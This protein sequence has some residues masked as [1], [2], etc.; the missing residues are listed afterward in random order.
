M[1]FTNFVIPNKFEDLVRDDGEN[2]YVKTIVDVC[3]LPAKL[4]DGK[5]SFKDDGVQFIFDHFDTYYSVIYHKA[6]LESEKLMIVSNQL[7]TALSALIHNLKFLLDDPDSLTSEIKTKYQVIIKMILY[8]FCHVIMAL[9]TKNTSQNMLLGIK[10][11]GKK[12]SSVSD[13]DECFNPKNALVTINM[14]LQCDLHVFWDPPVVEE[15]IINLVAEVCYPTLESGSISSNKEVRYEIFNIFGILIK[16]YSYDESLIV[17]LV[18]LLKVNSH[19]IK[20]I[21]EGI[22]Q[23]VENFSAKALIPEFVQEIMEILFDE[24]YEDAEATKHCTGTLVELSKLLPQL[25]AP[26]VAYLKSYLGHESHVL[27]NGVLVVMSEV[28]IIL[29]TRPALDENDQALKNLIL[30]VLQLHINDVAVTVRSKVIQTWAKVQKENLLN[31]T[32]LNDALRAIVA[33]ICDKGAAA[34]KNAA[35]TVTSFLEHN[36]YASELSLKAIQKEYQDQLDEF[37]KMEENIKEH[38]LNEKAADFHDEWN[39]IVA[40]LK[41]PKKKKTKNKSG[42]ANESND[43]NESDEESE[44]DD[45]CNESGEEMEIDDQSKEAIPSEQL[46]SLIKMYIEGKQY[47]DAFELCKRLIREVP[48]FVT[49]R[50]RDKKM[51]E[52]EFILEVLKGFYR[53]NCFLIHNIVDVETIDK[54]NRLEETVKHWESTVLFAKLL[55]DAMP[56]MSDLLESQNITEMQEAVKFFVTAYKFKLDGSEQRIL[57]LLEVMK[58]PFDDRKVI[59]INALVEV[60]LVTTLTNNMK[61]HVK[62]IVERLIRFTRIVTYAYRNSFERMIAEWTAKGKLDNNVLDMLFNYFTKKE[63]VDDDKSLAALQ[64][65]TLAAQGRQSIVMNNLKMVCEVVFE[66]RGLNDMAIVSEACHFLT[67][68]G[69]A[70]QRIEDDKP[71]YRLSYNETVWTQLTNILVDNFSKPVK[72]YCDAIS[73]AIPM[74]YKLCSTPEKIVQNLIMSIMKLDVWSQPGS[75]VKVPI[76]CIDRL[77]LILGKVAVYEMAHLDDTVYIE[78]KRRSNQRS[79]I[80]KMGRKRIQTP[81]MLSARKRAISTATEDGDDSI[82]DGADADDGDAQFVLNILE[83]KIVTNANSLGAFTPFFLEVCQN[84]TKF[85]N[86][87]IQCGSV[88]VLMRYMMMS[89]VM[90]RQYTTLIFQILSTTKSANLKR[91]IIINLADLL[92]RFPNIIDPY[93]AQIFDKLSDP[94]PGVQKTTYFILANLLTRNMLRVNKKVYVMTLPITQ[95]DSGLSGTAK[96]F[97]TQLALNHQ[98]QLTNILPDL[99]SFLC[100]REDV[101]EEQLRYIMK[102]IFDSI[103]KN[104]L[105]EGLV[106]RFC[107]K[108]INNEDDYI[109]SNVGFCLHQIQYNDKSARKLVDNFSNYKDALHNADLYSCF[110][111]IMA[112]WAKATK[113]NLKEVVVELEGKIAEFFQIKDLPPPSSTHVPRSSRKKAT[114]KKKRS[115]RSSS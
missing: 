47:K 46:L 23:L 43:E 65:L 22:N 98:A 39:A 24:K 33:H 83:Y 102:F 112:G 69:S 111:Q 49:K 26:E 21:A 54:M 113:Y 71:P 16:T 64:L 44:N 63:D 59:V 45:E 76:F 13:E 53:E 58:M 108:L 91:L 36:P 48:E 19:L 97:F 52:K 95:E 1:D 72:F 80:G 70:E 75:I 105:M 62:E 41:S 96:K 57:Q 78:I 37:R 40:E 32:Q 9:D 82:L 29:S 4:R 50:G 73:G 25:M 99:F 86:E 42:V 60:F 11:R 5:N 88:M 10:K 34:R 27:R 115:R 35:N 109:L 8:V 77:N 28:L 17:R 84:L 100:A 110:K 20:P 89:N 74:I 3:D 90:C 18:Q 103:D 31:P 51:D 81:S 56:K 15:Q 30:E 101:N 92:A 87:Q 6:V 114:Q 104:K 67:V 38:L 2:Y 68:A 61:E 93:S 55:D 85:P 14:L 12:K 94:D 66:N 106:D 79:S 107:A 7:E